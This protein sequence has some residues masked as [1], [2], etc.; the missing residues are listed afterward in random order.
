MN[1]EQLVVDDVKL[2]WEG[3]WWIIKGVKVVTENDQEPS[4]C[5][6]CY[7][8]DTGEQLYLPVYHEHRI[9]EKT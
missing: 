3:R 7:E 6:D 8:V 1:N 2:Q 4:I 5:F 9:V